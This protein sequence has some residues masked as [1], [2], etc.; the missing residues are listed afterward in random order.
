MVTKLT[1]IR[2]GKANET[3]PLAT[4]LFIAYDYSADHLSNLLVSSWTSL[5]R[6]S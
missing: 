2:R 1:F 5:S 6:V 4:A 3:P